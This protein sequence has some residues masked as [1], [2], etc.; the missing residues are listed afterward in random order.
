MLHSAFSGRRAGGSEPAA[1]VVLGIVAI[2]QIFGLSL[3]LYGGL[4]VP[5]LHQE[6]AEGG[7]FGWSGGAI[8]MVVACFFLVGGFTAPFCGMLGDRLDGRVSLV[9][10]ALLYGV[11]MVMMGLMRHEWH[12]FLAYGVILALSFSMALVPIRGMVSPWFQRRLGLAIGLIFTAGAVGAAGLT[13]LLALLVQQWGWTPAFVTFGVV[14]SAVMLGALPFY[15][16]NTSRFRRRRAAGE[17]AEWGRARMDA[18]RDFVIRRQIRNT[19]AFRMLPVIHGLGTGGHGIILVFA[20]DFAAHQ[21]LTS[22]A[23]ALVLTLSYVS[24][25]PSRLLV[26]VLAEGVDSRIVLSGVLMLQGISVV[27]LI[28]AHDAWMIYAAAVLFGIAYG[29]E[30][31]IFPVI[32]R[33]YFGDR[34]LSGVYGGQLMG[35]LVGQ[36]IAV[37][38]A[39]LAID[40]YGHVA[41]FALAVAL[42]FIGAALAWSIENARQPL[43]ADAPA[44]SRVWESRR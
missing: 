8:S 17:P 10:M 23:A 44:S 33:R 22:V 20:V 37:A 18:I 41:A 34:P 2:F 28:F 21:G 35:A 9:L 5:L 12:F 26:P 36:S 7:Q 27:G 43:V 29:G 24:C 3:Q 40:L 39:G 15:Q 30:S 6:A 25:I 19:Q 4:V 11:G 42:N 13:P 38:A 32:N 16:S 1:W 14:G 31:S